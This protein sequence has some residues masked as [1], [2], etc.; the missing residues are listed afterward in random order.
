MTAMS[1]PRSGATR[2][3]AEGFERG[4][5]PD[6]AR[7]LD[8]AKGSCGELRSMLYAAADLHYIAPAEAEEMRTMCRELSKGIAALAAHL[9]R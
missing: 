5:D 3:R 9:R 4:S 6:F 2:R 7:F 1:R 8:I